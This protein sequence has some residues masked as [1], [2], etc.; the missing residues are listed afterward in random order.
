MGLLTSCYVR[1]L[2]QTFHLRFGGVSLTAGNTLQ[3][4]D[5]VAQACQATISQLEEQLDSKDRQLQ[6]AR[7][8]C[9]ET[10]R[11]LS[12]SQT[13]LST[14]KRNL[15]AAEDSLT[16]FKKPPQTST[17]V[18]QNGTLAN[19]GLPSSHLG[20]EEGM[21]ELEAI[22]LENAALKTSNGALQKKISKND[23][24]VCPGH[25]INYAHSLAVLERRCS[26]TSHART[27]V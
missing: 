8:S 24:Q 26:H 14:I 16:Q 27:V 18:Y 1:G 22:R 19:K 20:L 12:F 11:E 6:A 10:T 25:L 17:G 9:N 7:H 4:A 2:M 15:Q 5:E 13:E 23:G 3:E 21:S